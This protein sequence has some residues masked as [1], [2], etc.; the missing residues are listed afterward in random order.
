MI[1]SLFFSVNLRLEPAGNGEAW[2]GR[3][4]RATLSMTETG[5]AGFPYW[6]QK[7]VICYK[8]GRVFC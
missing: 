4:P 2:R 5:Q 8:S 3:K 7:T 6:I 1:V